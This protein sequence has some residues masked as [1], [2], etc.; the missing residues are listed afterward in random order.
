M[1][2]RSP[3]SFLPALLLPL[4]LARP[5]LAQA[6]AA[7]P[8]P[9][10]AATPAATPAPPPP[11]PAVDPTT[12]RHLEELDQLAQATAGRLKALE[13]AAAARPKEAPPSAGVAADDKGFTIKSADGAYVLKLRALMQVD[14]RFFFDDTALRA[15]DTF[16]IRRFRP[17]LEGTLFSLVDYRL[18]PEFAGTFQILDAFVDI[19]PFEW[20][21]LRVGKFK[22]PIGLERLQSDADM[23]ILE[24]ALDQNLSSQREL[25]VQLWGDVAGGIAQYIVGV[26][27]GTVDGANGDTD[28]N[29]AK[30]LAGRLFFQPL[31]G[32][33]DYGNLGIGVAGSIGN[34]KGRLPSGSTAAVTGLPVLR[35]G[36]Q[37][38]FFQYFAPSTD[39][40]GATTTFT[41]ELTTHLNPSLYYY[42]DAFGLLAEYVRVGQGVQ[43]GAATATLHQ[44]SAHATL[45][46]AIGGRVGYDG[47]T[48]V[49]PFDR[50]SGAFGAFEIAVRYG[51]LAVDDATFADSSTSPATQYADPRNSAKSAQS[52]AGNLT[53]VPRRSFHL[54]FSF[55]HTVFDGGAGT[56][57][58]LTDRKAE[59][60]F[61]GRTQVN[62]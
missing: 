57:A 6:P 18:T 8:E 29:H 10:P 24:R 12:T 51:W 32:L 4:A 37:N 46:Y 47:V 35:S 21:R 56:T 40:T 60:V 49:T 25:G 58:A 44:Q 59:N 22:G 54:G 55:E 9:T 7:A 16:L 53:W 5:V 48:P 13:D 2:R 26:F 62:F 61:I 34:R 30:D 50:K 41:H 39:T 3:L 38:T 15:N 28:F 20:L 11:P 52:F 43:K 33:G 14:G 1:N 27:N 19:H 42:Y 36:G 17:A 45:N 31:K 23:P